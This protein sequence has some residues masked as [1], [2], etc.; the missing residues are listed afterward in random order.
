MFQTIKNKL[1][2]LR[3]DGWQNIF[4]N[5]GVN[6]SRTNTTFFQS[7]LNLPTATL[8]EIYQSNGIG[9]RIVNIIVEDALRGF[10]LSDKLLIEEL[11]RVNAKQSIM[12][13]AC[14]GRL[15]GGAILVA[16]IDDGLGFEK[17]INFNKINKLIS[18]KVFDKNQIQWNQEDLCK[19][20]YKPYYGDPEIYTI[21]SPQ[22]NSLIDGQFFK[23]HRSRCFTFSGDRL[24]NLAKMQNQGW[25]ASVLQSS[26][27]ALRNYGIVVSSSA[28]IV[29]D[30]IQVIMK[31]Q[32]LDK[33]LSTEGGDIEVKGRVDFI[34]Y[35]RSV[36]NMILLDGDGA[37]DYEKKAS[38]VA[39]LADLWDRFSETICASTGIP[40]TKLFGRSPGGLNSTGASD[41][42]NWYDIIRSYQTDQLEPAINWL[43]EILKHQKEW[44]KKPTQYHWR[45][46]SLTA[47]SESEWAD[48]KKKYAEIDCMYIDRGGI[49]ASDAW[50]ARF[51]KGE[52]EVN[53]KLDPPEIDN[54]LTLEE[55]NKDLTEN[56]EDELIT[57]GKRSKKIMDALYKKVL[58][59]HDE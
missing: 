23:V 25:D 21:T 32:G 18:L 1:S 57:D 16:F 10:I 20:F 34:D 6:N 24:V 54:Y 50:Q 36:S 12:D 17:P 13:A 19:D 4:T 43:I 41:I 49:D 26:Y 27:E 38:S 37:E 39:G 22:S 46:S 11:S 44:Q 40:A 47:P 28:E 30:F 45:F 55:D 58:K 56:P 8:S 3:R 52:F 15:Y 7:S 33:K 59:N 51:G 31:M 29:H 53:I 42:Q 35:T 9:K 48:I 14:F 2:K 5:L